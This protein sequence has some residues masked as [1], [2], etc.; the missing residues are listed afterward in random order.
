MTGILVGRLG[1]DVKFEPTGPA[2]GP[3]SGP[4]GLLHGLNASC[5][6]HAGLRMNSLMLKGYTTGLYARRSRMLG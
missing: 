1:S 4:A 5:W 3:K 2:L 6:A